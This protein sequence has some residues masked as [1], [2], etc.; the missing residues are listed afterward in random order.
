[1]TS[2]NLALRFSLGFFEWVSWELGPACSEPHACWVGAMTG[3]TVLTHWQQALTRQGGSKE[4]RG[5]LES[6]RVSAAPR[7]T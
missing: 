5:L 6:E 1:M 7:A 2:L 4:A 3:E